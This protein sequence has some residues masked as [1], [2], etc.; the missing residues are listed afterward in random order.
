M[1][2]NC[3]ADRLRSAGVTVHHEAAARAKS[4]RGP[5]RKNVGQKPRANVSVGS[6]PG[7]TPLNYYV[8]C[9]PESGHEVKRDNSAPPCSPSQFQDLFN[10][11]RCRRQQSM[12][13]RKPQR[14]CSF[15]I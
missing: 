11:V 4:R 6:K 3:I 12:G 7:F 5:K 13:E 2:K 15:V 14:L 10:H 8:R 1:G 9:Y